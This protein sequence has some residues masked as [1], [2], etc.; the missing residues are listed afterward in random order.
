MR[1]KVIPEEEERVRRFR[2]TRVLLLNLL[3]IRRQQ[4]KS[5]EWNQ[6]E[7]TLEVDSAEDY[8]DLLTED[9]A[10]E[11]EENS[12]KNWITMMIMRTITN[13]LQQGCRK[14]SSRR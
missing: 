5:L 3:R 4:Q 14:S 7:L 10:E 9:A 8:E 1:L 12:K 11:L 6:K 13:R 2:Y